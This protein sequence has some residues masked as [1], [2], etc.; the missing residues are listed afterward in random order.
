MLKTI[1]LIDFK[2]YRIPNNFTQNKVEL[3]E[4]FVSNFLDNEILSEMLCVNNQGIF[5]YG[6][7]S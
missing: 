2:A 1:L 7:P 6:N 5:I 3:P 4:D